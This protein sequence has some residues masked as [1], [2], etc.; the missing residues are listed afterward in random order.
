MSHV[1]D[2]VVISV[3]SE[4]LSKN[5]YSSRTEFIPNHKLQ[6]TVNSLVISDPSSFWTLEWKIHSPG[7]RYCTVYWLAPKPRVRSFANM[8]FSD[9]APKKGFV[10]AIASKSDIKKSDREKVLSLLLFSLNASVTSLLP[11]SSSHSVADLYLMYLGGKLCFKT[12]FLPG[13]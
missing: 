5:F 9:D 8:L 13:L 11:A 1:F 4:V 3:F 2:W 7:I 10:L 12:F 6:S